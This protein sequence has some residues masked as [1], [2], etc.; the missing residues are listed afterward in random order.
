MSSVDD[1]ARPGRTAAATLVVLRLLL[2]GV[3]LLRLVVGLLRSR[4]P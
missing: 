1:A 4:P 3:N 2:G